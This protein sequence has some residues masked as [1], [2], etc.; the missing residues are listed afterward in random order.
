MSTQVCDLAPLAGLSALRT[1]SAKNTQV[2]DL[3]PLARLSA[4]QWLNVSNTQVIDLSPLAGL[5]A[6]QRLN[7]SFAQVKRPLP[8]AR[9]HP[10]WPP[11]EMELQDTAKVTAST[12]KT[13]RLPI[14]RPRS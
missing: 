1:L 9:P 6:L 4:L 11:G 2:T 14:H 8:I 10:S 13:V 12:S 5:T 7:V 3:T